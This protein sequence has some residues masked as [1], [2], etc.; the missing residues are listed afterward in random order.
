MKNIGIAL[1]D[2]KSIIYTFAFDS[3]WDRVQTYMR[4][5]PNSLIPQGPYKSEPQE[6]LHDA[7]WDYFTNLD[8][9]ASIVFD[10]MRALGGDP[11]LFNGESS[12]SSYIDEVGIDTKKDTWRE[13]YRKLCK[14]TWSAD[15]H[16]FIWLVHSEFLFEYNYS[17]DG[18]EVCKSYVELLEKHMKEI[19]IDDYFHYQ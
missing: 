1:D 13:A 16:W 15:G 11:P 4:E 10:L 5:H 8:I 7:W 18:K 3:V 6:V 2:L 17:S 9:K 19:N 14:S 12:L